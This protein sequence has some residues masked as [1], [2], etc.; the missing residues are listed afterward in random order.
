ME[1]LGLCELETSV[2][3][4]YLVG[5]TTLCAFSGN[6]RT[7][8]SDV[9]GDALIVG[10]ESSR[11]FPS[12]NWCNVINGKLNVSHVHLFA[13]LAVSAFRQSHRHFSRLHER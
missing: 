13:R 11:L 1:Y 10:H 12:Y 2:H 9:P 5:Q 8:A 4:W 3:A 6:Y 7:C